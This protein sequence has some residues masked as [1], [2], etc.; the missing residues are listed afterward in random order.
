MMKT[1]QLPMSNIIALGIIAQLSSI[2][3]LKLWGKYTDRFS[4]KT[5]IRICAPIFVACILSWSFTANKNFPHLSLALLIVIH[6]ISGCS[7]A[8]INLA[9]NN[10][11][12]KLAPKNEAIVYIS[13][14]NIIVNSISAIAPLVGGLMA[15]FFATH[16][17][18]WVVEWQGASGVIKLPL[19]HLQGWTFFFVLGSMTAL[20]ALRFLKNID[21]AGEIRKRK[22]LIYMRAKLV[23][24][25][26]CSLGKASLSLKTNTQNAIPTYKRIMIK[27]LIAEE[28]KRA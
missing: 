24:N 11:A 17:L 9:I 27:N 10:F 18:T 16:Q 22:V 6:I 13:A 7:A 3:S 23:K 5:I 28:K 19:I 1:L 2:F 14:K 4:N 21:E 25:I 26:T 8:G 12:T 15:D 20:V